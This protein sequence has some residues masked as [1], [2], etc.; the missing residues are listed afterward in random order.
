M[1]FIT[2]NEM[3]Y[4]LS[5]TKDKVYI[6]IVNRQAKAKKKK[7]YIAVDSNVKRLL[8]E[9]NIIQDS[10]TIYQSESLI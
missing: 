1:Q 8:N 4:I 5:H 3:N 2:K 10:K 7:R 6:T 9:Y